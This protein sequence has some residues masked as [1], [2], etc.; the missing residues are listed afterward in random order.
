MASAERSPNFG[1]APVTA[2]QPIVFLIVDKA[3]ELRVINTTEL[4]GEGVAKRM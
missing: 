3:Q 1:G 2:P 4:L